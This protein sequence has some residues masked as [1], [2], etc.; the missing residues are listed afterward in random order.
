MWESPE[1]EMC[2]QPPV[3]GFDA[4]IISPSK[5]IP[6]SNLSAELCGNCHTGKHEEVYEEWNE[7]NSIE[8]DPV[9]TA[10][11]S[12][13]SN[14]EDRIVLNRSTCVSCK[15]T[16]GAILNIEDAALYG[17]SKDRMPD[18]ED[19][20]EW[21]I[22]CIACHAPHSTELR[23]TP[24][25]LCASC[26]N[27]DG[28]NPD[29]NTTIVRYTQWEMYNGSIYTNGVHAVNLGCVDCHMA[30]MIEE[31][32]TIVTGHSFD[33]EPILLSDPNSGN[34]CKKC[35]VMSHDEIPVD[36]ECDDCHDVSLSNILEVNQETIKNKL[37]ELEPLEKNASMAL[38]MISNNESY[39]AKLE[40]YNN[41]LFYISE[42]ESDGSFGMHNMERATNNLDMAETLLKS[43]IEE[44]TAII[45]TD[46]TSTPGFGIFAAVSLI[47]IA[48]FALCRER[49]RRKEH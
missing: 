4:H 44:G 8:F 41:A 27:S 30:M 16:E 11:H 15:S 24:T 21:R 18:T 28:A 40:N 6:Q 22:T 32:E 26:H 17:R 9:T 36:N 23:T 49:K 2:H 3:E 1:C 38:T 5:A 25:Q 13:P 14:I 47:T 20:T 12:E 46:E 19:I 35:H 48:A 39:D 42:V 7:Y 33:F 45:G 10:S 43:V 34:I 29:G 31:N 37:K